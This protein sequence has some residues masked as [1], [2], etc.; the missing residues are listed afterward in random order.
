MN[1]TLIALLSLALIGC[2]SQKD[3]APPSKKLNQPLNYLDFSDDQNV[4]KTDLYWQVKSSQHPQYPASQL[5]KRASGCTI[6]TVGIGPDGNPVGYKIKKSFPEGAFDKSAIQALK[7][8]QWEPTV[9]NKDRQ[10]VLTSIKLD[11][12]V[13]GSRNKREA[14]E[15]CGKRI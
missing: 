3:K 1:K 11:F 4:S 8:W 6:I 14:E 13:D 2:Q 9:S 5:S 12:Y 7:N 10:P 15:H